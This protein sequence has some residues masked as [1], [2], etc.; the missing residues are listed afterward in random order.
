MDSC[1]VE[2]G[3]AVCQYEPVDCPEGQVCHP[4][5]GE[6]VDC[7][8]DADC[9]D[10]LFC[11]GVESCGESNTCVPGD[12]PC[13]ETVLCNEETDAC[14]D[15]LT[16]ADCDDEVFCNGQETCDPANGQCVAGAPPCA[17]RIC[18]EETDAC[19]DCLTDADCDDDLFCNGVETCDLET[20]ACVAGTAP[21]PEGE[22]CVEGNKACLECLSDEDCPNGQLCAPATGRCVEA[23]LCIS[24]QECD[25][26]DPCTVNTCVD[27]EC[28]STPKDCNDH[29]FC[30]GYEYCDP[31]TGECVSPGNPC[32]E[33]EPCYEDFDACYIDWECIFSVGPDRILLPDGAHTCIASDETYET[34]D[35]LDGGG[36]PDSL[37]LTTVREEPDVA[38][39]INVEHGF[40]RNTYPGQSI[41]LD[42]WTGYEELWYDRGTVDVTLTQ[43]HEL[44]A[45]GMTGGDQE[46]SDLTVV[47]D[48]E[49][50][51]GNDDSL[52]VLLTDA[53]GGDIVAKDADGNDGFET[54]NI[55]FDGDSEIEAFIT[56]GLKSVVLIGAGSVTIIEPLIGATAIDASQA[57][58]DV[59]VRSDDLSVTVTG[60]SG[61][62]TLAGGAGDDS[63]DGRDA[64]DA[65]TGGPG[66]DELTGGAGG[67][68]FRYTDRNDGAGQ[69]LTG[70]F[71]LDAAD[72]IEAFASGEDT[73]SF[74]GSFLDNDVASDVPQG[75]VDFSVHGFIFINDVAAATLS[76]EHDVISA[77]GPV[78][79]DGD[80]N[81]AAFVINNS[82]GDAAGLY[83]F[84]DNGTADGVIMPGELHLLAVVDTPVAFA[85]LAI[86]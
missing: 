82:S 29:L 12:D 57:T 86:H 14:A 63:I 19:V 41:S 25:D 77:I 10:G 53:G 16:D 13:T 24:D 34:G 68:A 54:V 78:T 61:N 56:P 6:C 39:I 60:G 38:E 33:G 40:F 65:M 59:S 70:S 27:C 11:N 49:L 9:D 75:G 67:D 50:V 20:G 55:L 74:S 1:A 71:D 45:I 58:G 80:N 22:F 32:G 2:D 3:E 66:A 73:L 7:L 36:G 35:F 72:S 15:C 79:N 76:R 62:D 28:V 85:D 46:N 52:E 4:E 31:E 47:F 81:R 23:C 44:A 42:L 64:D 37:H 69:A 83:A 5:S 17:D 21:C 30:N 8:E 48:D 43:L 51:V 84:V 26:G 18:V